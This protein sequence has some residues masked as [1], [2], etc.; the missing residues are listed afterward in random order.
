[1]AKGANLGLLYAVIVLVLIYAL[2][3]ALSSSPRRDSAIYPYQVTFGDGSL[4]VNDAA[5]SH[6]GFEYAAEYGVSVEQACNGTV[7]EGHIAGLVFTLKTGLGDALRV[8]ELDLQ[9]TY[10]DEDNQIV[11]VG[12]EITIRL[13]KVEQDRV[14]NHAWDGY[15][16][17]SF[18]SSAPVGEIMGEISPQVFGLPD[19]YYV[20]L[21]LWATVQALP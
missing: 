5:S 20:E 19:Q 12:H 15:Y 2:A 10:D 8:H 1:M 11:L 13:V 9:L 7:I 18:G 21:R 16:I 3:T 14:W 6:G 17:A 4:Y